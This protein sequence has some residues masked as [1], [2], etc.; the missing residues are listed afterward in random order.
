MPSVNEKNSVPVE[1]FQRR[2]RLLERQG[3]DAYVIAI[4]LDWFDHNGR[5]DA[6]RVKR[7]L[8][9]QGQQNGANRKTTRRERLKFETAKR[10]AD[11]MDLD[12]QA[13]GL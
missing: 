13:C 11:A 7:S 12:Y 4:R 5:P 8:G 9:L 6:H 10:L 1:P 3:V 2:Y